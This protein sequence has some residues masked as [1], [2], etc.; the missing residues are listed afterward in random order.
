MKSTV[1]ANPTH[2]QYRQIYGNEFYEGF[3]DDI[4]IVKI[5]DPLKPQNQEEYICDLN[6]WY[7]MLS[8]LYMLLVYCE[9]VVFSIFFCSVLSFIK[10]FFLIVDEIPFE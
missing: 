9:I 2:D 5:P 10:R 1:T 3:V 4:P 6:T 8:I 7:Q